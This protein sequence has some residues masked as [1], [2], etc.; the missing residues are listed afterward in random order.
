MLKNDDTKIIENTH[1]TIY[2]D[3]ACSGNPGPGAFAIIILINNQVIHKH[4]TFEKETTSNRME[5]SALLWV[6]KNVSSPLINIYSDSTYVV[7]G[8]NTWLAGWKIKNW[9]TTSGPVKN[10][11]LWQEVDKHILYKKSKN[12]I[13]NLHWVKGHSNNIYNNQVDKMARDSILTNK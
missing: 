8:I 4:T 7:Q 1:L 6:L 2:T 10:L 13:F 12:E 3:G 9:K 11:D 5:L